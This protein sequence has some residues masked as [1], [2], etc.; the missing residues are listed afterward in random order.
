MS[1][2]LASMCGA[3]RQVGARGAESAA[4]R[5]VGPEFNGRALG[6]EKRGGQCGT[7]ESDGACMS[8]C[9]RFGFLVRRVGG[10]RAASWNHVLSNH[11]RLETGFPYPPK[12][13]SHHSQ[14]VCRKSKVD[15][16]EAASSEL[17]LKRQGFRT[18]WLRPSLVRMDQSVRHIFTIRYA[19]SP[20]MIVWA[21]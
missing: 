16:K 6:V 7:R 15:P 12:R 18:D 13:H 10:G 5:F 8:C 17:G 14:G 20:T 2:R 11:S 19:S 1:C 3:R 9:L 4:A 21:R